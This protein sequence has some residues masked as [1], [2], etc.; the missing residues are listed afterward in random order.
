MKKIFLAGQLWF[1]LF[2][3]LTVLSCT[4]KNKVP[5]DQTINALNLTKGDIIVCGLPTN[6]LALLSLRYPVQKK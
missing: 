2:F 4:S 3:V 1:P 5:S 6:N